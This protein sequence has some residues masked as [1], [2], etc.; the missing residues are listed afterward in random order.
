MWTAKGEGVPEKTMS[1]HKREGV[2]EAGSRGQNF[3]YTTA[4]NAVL[5]R[6]VNLVSSFFEFGYLH[7]SWHK[8][9]ENR[10]FRSR[11]SS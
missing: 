8:I 7:I 9:F 6:C 3:L 1:V 11:V 2:L 4:L 5:L 10:I